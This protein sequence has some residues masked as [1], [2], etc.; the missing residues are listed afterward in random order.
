MDK[1]VNIKRDK[2]LTIEEI[3]ACK[4]YKNLSDEQAQRLIE[5]LKIYTQVIYEFY[6]K[7]S[8]EEKSEKGKIVPIRSYHLKNKAA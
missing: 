8:E 7:K 4:E 3:R 1:T 5:T 6:R 2:D